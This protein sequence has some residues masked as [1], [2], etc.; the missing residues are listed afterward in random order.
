[1]AKH[2]RRRSKKRIS[3]KFVAFLVENKIYMLG[4]A[5]LLVILVTLVVMMILEGSSKDEM[6]SYIG[7]MYGV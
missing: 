6:L 5:L 1:M 3:N 7:G 2:R 4:A